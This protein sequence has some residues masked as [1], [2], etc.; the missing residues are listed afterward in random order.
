MTVCKR[1]NAEGVYWERSLT[2]KWTLFEESTA[3]RHF[4]Q[5]EKLKAIKCKYCS[6]ADLHWAEEVDPI[7]Q[8]KKMVLTE[9]YGLPHACDE[10]IAFVAKEKKEKKDKYEAEKTRIMNV[11][12]GICS[13]CRGTGYSHN[14]TQNI[15]GTCGNCIGFGSFSERNRKAMLANVRLKI[16]PNMRDN[17][18]NK[19]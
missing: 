16:W 9:S 15:L 7:T 5:D 4:C 2:G 10:R 14:A 6:S 8:N 17:Y 1:C 19:W 3:K 12:D 13:A 11:P 18:Y